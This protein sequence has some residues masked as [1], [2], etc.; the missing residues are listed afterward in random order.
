MSGALLPGG[1]RDAQAT[2]HPVFCK[3]GLS[4]VPSGSCGFCLSF[5]VN[6]GGGSF[7]R[8]SVLRSR[9]N[10]KTRRGGAG[11]AHLFTQADLHANIDYAA[12]N[13]KTPEIVSVDGINS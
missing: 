5:D 11:R 3:S 8:A 9:Q 1:I 2:H 12:A 13:V 10:D 7:R 4:R 6:E